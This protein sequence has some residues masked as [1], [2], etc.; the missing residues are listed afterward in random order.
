[1][2]APNDVRT[3]FLIDLGLELPP[4]IEEL[5]G[6]QFYTQISAERLDLLEAVDALVLVAVGKPQ[7]RRLLDSRL[8]K[9]L[10]PVRED[11]VVRIDDPDLAIAM[12]YS[13]VLSIPYQLSE[14]VPPLSE[15]L[16]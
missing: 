2:F 15:A 3:R 5:F 1:M 10:G 8:F 14:V 16:A 12:S 11:R 13:S 6:D 4:A 7:T 9:G